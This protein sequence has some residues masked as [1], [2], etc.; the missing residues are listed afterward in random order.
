[1]KEFTFKNLVFYWLKHWYITLVLVIIAVA[2]GYFVFCHNYHSQYLAEYSFLVVNDNQNS[3]GAD[4]LSAF[5]SIEL[6]KEGCLVDSSSTNGNVVSFKA[7]CEKSIEEVEAYAKELV[8][9]FDTL[10]GSIYKSDF[11]KTVILKDDLG[12]E[13]TSSGKKLIIVTVAA[14]ALSCAIAFIGLDH[15]VSKKK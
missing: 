14:A 2:G 10:A 3:L 1:M 12:E 15:E 13:Y 8:K 6:A 4:Y 9:S 5:N 11:E 7:V